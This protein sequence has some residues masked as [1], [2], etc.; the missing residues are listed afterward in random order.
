MQPCFIA[1]Q[2]TTAPTQQVSGKPNSTQAEPKPVEPK[3]T[4]V[5]PPV[6][7]ATNLPT[8]NTTKKDSILTAAKVD[9]LFT[10]NESNL[11]YYVIAVNDMSLSVSSSR[12]GVGQFN[13]G[14]YAGTGI[15]HQLLEM[16]E[17]QLIFVGNSNT[18]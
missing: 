16:D 3:P 4:Q 9:A 14:N 15:K 6:N 12:F 13:R 11:Y 2:N 8:Q 10:K 5:N 1:Q 7:P 17:D 18:L